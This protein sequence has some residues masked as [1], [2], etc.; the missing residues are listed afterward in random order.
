LGYASLQR[1]GFELALATASRRVQSVSLIPGDS[2]RIV[3]TLD[4]LKLT[5]TSMLDCFFH[6]SSCWPPIVV[7]LGVT[8]GA[9]LI[10]ERHL[11]HKF[12]L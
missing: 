12:H 8:V 10:S 7:L 6:D 11:R 3:D 4:H 1:W 5:N 9:V 2:L